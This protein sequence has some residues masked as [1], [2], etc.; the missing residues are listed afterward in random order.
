MSDR[1]APFSEPA[2]A[3]RA[4]TAVPMVLRQ[5]VLFLAAGSVGVRAEG[6][7]VCGL[8]TAI[9][10]ASLVAIL[11]FS[12]GFDE[13]S[14]WR[15]RKAFNSASQHPVL[16]GRPIPLGPQPPQSRLRVCLPSSLPETCGPG[17]AC[18][19]LGLRT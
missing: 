18:L 6:G 9:V 12:S 15:Q 5:L 4:V 2:A 14:R 17:Q 19:S 3:F 10:S 7:W 16:R 11:D 13:E 1:Q 8:G